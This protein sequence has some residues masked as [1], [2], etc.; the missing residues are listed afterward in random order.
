MIDGVKIKKLKVSPTSAGLM[1]IMRADDEF[2]EKF[3]Q[4]T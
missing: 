2:F 4:V 3:G 1:E